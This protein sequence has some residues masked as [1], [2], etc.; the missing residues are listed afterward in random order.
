MN[1][2]NYANRG[3]S[4]EYLINFANQ[5]YLAKRVALVQYIPT[6]W[7]VIRWGTQIISAFPAHKSTVDYI[8]VRN[9]KGETVPLAFDAKQCMRVFLY[10]ILSNTSLITLSSGDLLVKQVFSSLK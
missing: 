3:K 5:Q 8:G 6:D 1:S 2:A 10:Q 9:F 7:T 4:L